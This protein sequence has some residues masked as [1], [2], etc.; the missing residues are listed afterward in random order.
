MSRWIDITR[1]MDDNLLCWP[2]RRPP[3]RIW[4]KTIAKGH[5][6]N[7]SQWS[8]GAH[9]GTH[10]DAPL[11]FIDGGASI[12]RVPPDMLIGPCRVLRLESAEQAPLDLAAVQPCC[13]EQRLLI[14]THHGEATTRSTIPHYKPHDALLSPDASRFLLDH[15]LAVLG[16]DRLS[17]DDS[18]GDGFDVHHLV[19]GRGG[20]I[21]EGLDLSQVAPGSYELHA[22]PLRL[23][24]AEAS[25]ARVLLHQ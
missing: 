14:R 11:H 22:T 23:A 25:P 18:R 5:H 9:T 20:V 19:L 3:Q 21:I 2:G 16:T 4:E 13:G 6:C 17:V 15:G 10:I 1:P 8:F 7:V 12:D 24:G